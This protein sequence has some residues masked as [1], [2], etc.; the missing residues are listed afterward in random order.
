MSQTC[1]CSC[2]RCCV[3]VCVCD[4]EIRTLSLFLEK[5]AAVSAL[6]YDVCAYIMVCE[7]DREA[8]C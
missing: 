8:G 6:E 1:R 7:L 3:C 5:S 2:C 4:L